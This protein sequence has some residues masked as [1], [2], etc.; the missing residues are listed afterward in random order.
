MSLPG[1]LQSEPGPLVLVV[2]DDLDILDVLTLVLEN[3]RYRVLTATDGAAALALLRRGER[4]AVIILDLMMPGMDG[5]AFCE[6]RRG[7]AALTA[8]PIVVLSGDHLALQDE[9]PPGVCTSLRKP[10]DLDTLLTEVDRWAE[11]SAP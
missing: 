6:C 9:P 1:A 3:A 2:D 4:P 7:D 5:W 10:V 8:I 11:R